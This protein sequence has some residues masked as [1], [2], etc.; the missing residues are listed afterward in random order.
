MNEPKASAFPYDYRNGNFTATVYRREYLKSGASYT[1]FKAAFY[2]DGN[3]RQFRT[4][5]TWEGIEK[6]ITEVRAH[7][8]QSVIL[9]GQEQLI[10]TRAANAVKPF[11]VALDVAAMDYAKLREMLGSVS[12]DEV[13]KFWRDRH[14]VTSTKTVQEVVDEMIAKLEKRDKKPS[15]RYIEDVRS[16]GDKFAGSFPGVRM[17]QVTPTQIEQFLD[18]YKG[19]TRFNYSRS[20]KQFYNYARIKKYVAKD[21]NE[22]ENI[23]TDYEDTSE[24]EIFTPAE[25]TKLLSVARPE[26]VPFLAIGSFAGLRSAE[27]ARLDW[28]EILTDHIV[29][30]KGKA[31]TRSRRLIPIQ[32]N[33]AQWL[34]PHRKESGPVVQFSCIGTQ[35]VA[36]TAE[37]EVKWKHNAMRHS[38]ISYRLATTN[39]EGRVA[40]EAGNSP[41]MIH[42]NY[43]QLV[44]ETDA[45][46]WFAIAPESAKKV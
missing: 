38:Y 5:S 39:D 24:I 26:M 13:G 45:K 44:T 15:P 25:I 19:R 10:Y 11:G 33:L 3:R 31:K 18:Q 22:F 28:S 7:E 4:A 27:I 16:R 41:A 40:A 2:D 23:D 6:A 36:L 9:K 20:I 1:E 21:F 34:A 46:A 29:I 32:P 37:A 14:T 42:G 17:D 8:S 12:F 43:R 30:K 35:V